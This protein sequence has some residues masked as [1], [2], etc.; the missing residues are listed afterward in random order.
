MA[1]KMSV[2]QQMMQRMGQR[3]GGQRQQQVQ[4]G[5]RQRGQRGQRQPGQRRGQRGQASGAQEQAPPAGNQRQVRW[6]I[7]VEGDVPLKVIASSQRGGTD[8]EEL[9]IR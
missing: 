8:V 9:T 7:A 2:L 3:Q 4:A 5:Q 6:L 1:L